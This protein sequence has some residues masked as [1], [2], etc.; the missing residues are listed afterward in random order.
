M[1]LHEM[2]YNS[3]TLDKV[4]SEVFQVA[5][6]KEPHRVLWLCPSRRLA[7]DR[8]SRF[9][10][11]LLSHGRGG[12]F[13]P[14]FRTLNDFAVEQFSLRFPF[15]K[16]MNQ[17]ESLWTVEEAL[18][19]AGGGAR[20]GLSGELLA[21]LSS[22]KAYISNDPAEVKKA[23]ESAFDEWSQDFQPAL[24]AGVFERARERLN[25]VLEVFDGHE[26]LK[27]ERGLF[28]EFDACYL[29]ELP[30]FE[31]ELVVVD[32][33]Q[34]FY[35]A[36]RLLLEKILEASPRTMLLKHEFRLPGEKGFQLSEDL[37]R[38]AISITG[39]PTPALEVR[40]VADQ[41]ASLIESGVRPEEILV[42][43]PDLSAYARALSTVFED[44]GIKANIS[45]GY[46]LSASLT[47]SFL[48]SLLDYMTD[49]D[50]AAS[51]YELVLSFLI[52]RVEPEKGSAYAAIKEFFSKND[53]YA[54]EEFLEKLRLAFS[55][56]GLG[57]IANIFEKVKALKS[58]K[59]LS[60][61]LDLVE[62]VV[63]LVHGLSEEDQ[64]A[65]KDLEAI[66]EGINRFRSSEVF[67]AEKDRPLDA[68]RLVSIFKTILAKPSRSFS[69]DIAEGVQVSGVLETRG[70]A[71]DFVFLVG[72]TDRAFPGNPLKTYLL[73]DGL[74]KRLKIPTSD[75][76][77]QK[78]KKDFYR[79]VSS[80]R[81]GVFISF[82]Q[83]EK[84]EVFL[85][86]R[87]VTE[88]RS[89][90]KN[91]LVS[92]A[93]Q[94]DVEDF[95][96]RER[97][98]KPAV[99]LNLKEAVKPLREPVNLSVSTLR[100]VVACR[101][102]FYLIANDFLTVNLPSTI[103]G[104]QKFGNLFHKM[105]SDFI[106]AFNGKPEERV[107]IDE[108]VN[109]WIESNLDSERFKTYGLEDFFGKGRMVQIGTRVLADVEEYLLQTPGIV[110]PEIEMENLSK[111]FVHE[112]TGTKVTVRGRPDLVVLDEKGK[113]REIVDFKFFEKDSDMTNKDILEE[114]R[115][116]LYLYSFLLSD[117]ASPGEFV[118]QAPAKARMVG[119]SLTSNKSVVELLK[120]DDEQN[121]KFKNYFL[122]AVEIA[123]RTEFPAVQKCNEY[124]CHLFAYCPVARGL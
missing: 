118:A 76:Y 22:F 104:S 70:I 95:V 41:I 101:A 27:R 24:D 112:G 78:Q 13:L 66:L 84:N 45:F 75:E 109:G 9:A 65:E 85:E 35:P 7:R 62:Q 96:V 19:Q 113:V 114:Y 86:S 80:A 18:L 15:L 50:F 73:P 98:S 34:D 71:S 57:E 79:L 38:K 5:W 107:R 90:L 51:F 3:H 25:R 120:P 87:F 103:P 33:F 4:L 106:S 94:F 31:Y 64:K 83:Q 122:E 44:K 23:L 124:A 56:R 43:V 100:H 111:T 105:I 82:Y 28:D 115:F 117:A 63:F 10:R 47:G 89:L 99:R 55:K 97:R 12:S 72:F 53:F 102:K 1:K 42:V 61:A 39:Y 14:N 91:G 8:T 30:R 74:K 54:K 121:E 69:G 58:A 26:R 77:L 48:L 92:G 49:S 81:H 119:F 20:P 110:R 60:D 123:V 17:D 67:A 46:S 37:R 29:E 36:Q 21:L 32:S 93:V 11:F 52:A 16:F 108:W 68:G 40:S 59:N 116:Q 6:K 2:P 88:L